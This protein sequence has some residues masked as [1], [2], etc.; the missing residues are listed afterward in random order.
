MEQQGCGR[1]EEHA[2]QREASHHAGLDLLWVATS[3][4]GLSLQILSIDGWNGSPIVR[5]VSFYLHV[6][7]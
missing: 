4:R 6:S 2:G 3:G 1:G 5:A 7:A